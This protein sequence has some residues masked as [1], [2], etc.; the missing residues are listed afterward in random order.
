MEAANHNP[1]VRAAVDAARPLRGVR[2]NAATGASSAT[3][4]LEPRW[5]A[6]YT[7]ANHEKRVARQLTERSLE[8]FL[9]TYESMRRWKDRRKRLELP[10]FPGYVFV[11]LAMR[12]RLRVLQVPG[13]AKLVG[14]GGLPT[15]L[16]EGEIEALRASLARGVRAEPHP[17]VQV[18]R[19]VRVTAGALAGV[20]GRVVRR[21][22]RSRFVISLDL[23]QR[24]VAVE[25]EALEVEPVAE[26]RRGPS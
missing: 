26:T 16:P 9:P 2:A 3:D 10:L 12:D 5:Y 15:A 17:Y 20:E 19:R 22:N 6:A 25:V 18:G 21:K 13:V 14:F 1:E 4:L 11:H 23:I 24:S 7:S 8:H